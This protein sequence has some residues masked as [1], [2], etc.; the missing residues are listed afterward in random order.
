MNG[1]IRVVEDWLIIVD[2]MNYIPAKDTRRTRVIERKGE[3]PSEEPVYDFRAYYTDLV[4]AMEYI[5]SETIRTRL[6]DAERP[7]SEALHII[8]E[9]NKEFSNLLKKV[10]TEGTE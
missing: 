6:Q 7:L 4:G 9:A 10:T 2:D 1:L 8:K 3:Q 5:R